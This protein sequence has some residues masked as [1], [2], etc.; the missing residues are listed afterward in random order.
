M[1]FK[2]I[3]AKSG[4][5]P[6]QCRCGRK[7]NT[8]NV[9]LEFFDQIIAACRAGEEVRVKNFGIFY[10]LLTQGRTISTPV[11]PGNKAESQDSLTL[12]FRQ[13]PGAKAKLNNRKKKG[14]TDGQSEES[15]EEN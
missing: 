6:I 15:N 1:N 2:E 14:D 12:K 7:I 8:M 5:A 4:L 11:L 9:L 3:A 10:A 13:S